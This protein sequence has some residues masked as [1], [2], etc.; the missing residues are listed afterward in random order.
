MRPLPV[1]P[2]PAGA[3]RGGPAGG[4]PPGGTELG[5][6]RPFGAVS[7]VPAPRVVVTPAA[8]PLPSLR[9]GRFL[10]WRWWWG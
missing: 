7:K 10:A 5:K 8:A 6:T 1:P 4:L 3:L 2:L 9:Y